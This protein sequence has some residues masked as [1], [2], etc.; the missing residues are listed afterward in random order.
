MTVL[1]PALSLPTRQAIV[2]GRASERL[3]ERPLEVSDATLGYSFGPTSGVFAATFLGK[4][5][6]YFALQLDPTRDFPDVTGAGTITLTL[7]LT[8]RDGTT[9]VRTADVH[10]ADLTP[11]ERPQTIDGQ[12]LTVTHLPGAPVTMD[13]QRDPAPVQLEALVL[14][15]NNPATPAV[16]V[17]VTVGGLGPF[18]T[19]TDGRFRTTALPLQISVAVSITDGTDTT[20]HTQALDFTTP[21]NRA[22]FAFEPVD[23]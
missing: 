6:G 11:T 18:A 20:D 21:L 16:G 4:P 22:T 1:S 14:I 19:D 5:G 9:E 13:V 23:D 3:T 7:T 15:H 10:E 17:D 8:L 2:S 12:S